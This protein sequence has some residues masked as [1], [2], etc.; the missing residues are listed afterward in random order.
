MAENLWRRRPLSENPYDWTAFQ[1]VGISPDVVG[2]RAINAAVAN[3]RKVL[4]ALPGQRRIAGKA[5]DQAD[6]TAA[7]QILT[8]PGKRILEELLEHHP[9]EPQSAELQRFQSLFTLKDPNA[10]SALPIRHLRFLQ[11]LIPSLLERAAAQ[12]PPVQLPMP[13]EDPTRVPPFN[14]GDY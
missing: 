5:V 14:Q 1:I 3:A 8:D 6:L 9:E 12:L 2:R 4:Q 10:G 11:L 13:T 7:S